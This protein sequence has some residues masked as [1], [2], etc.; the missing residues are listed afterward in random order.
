MKI[1]IVVLG[2]G[3][4]EEG[5]KDDKTLGKKRKERG[6]LGKNVSSRTSWLCGRGRNGAIDKKNIKSVKN[7]V[8]G[9]QNGPGLGGRQG[10]AKTVK[11]KNTRKTQ[12][13]AIKKRGMGQGGHEP[14]DQW[15]F[16]DHRR[17]KYELKKTGKEKMYTT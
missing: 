4:G 9:E 2:L 1:Y 17:Q 5:N 8:G 10:A 3:A 12:K 15:G 11:K 13:K 16:G 14:P 7:A 6:L